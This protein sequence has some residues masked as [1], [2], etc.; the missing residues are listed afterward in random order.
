MP[1]SCTSSSVVVFAQQRHHEDV[2]ILSVDVALLAEQSFADEAAFLVASHRAGIVDQHAEPHSIQVH[3]VERQANND[4]ECIAAEALAPELFLSDRDE[5]FR[6]AAFP[7][8]ES[9]P[10]IADQFSIEGFDRE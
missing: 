6:L 1:S 3:F 8:D 10:A 4:P 2:A 5:E 9:E 7:V